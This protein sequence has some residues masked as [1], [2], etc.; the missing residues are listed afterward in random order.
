MWDLQENGEL[1][2]FWDI[3][4]NWEKTNLSPHFPD[5]LKN[6]IAM[7]IESSNTP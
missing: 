7:A 2:D 5:I 3:S 4:D 6:H 1:V